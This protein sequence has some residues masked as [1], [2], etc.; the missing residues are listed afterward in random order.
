MNGGLCSTCPNYGFQQH[1]GECWHDSFSML[2]LYSDEL[3]EHIQNIFDK[4]FDK[5]AEY[6]E[7]HSPKYLLPMN[8]EPE[9]YKE[10]IKWCKD[11]FN[12]MYNRYNN[13]KLTI[14]FTKPKKDIRLRS[15]I[16]NGGVD[17]EET[18]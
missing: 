9:N 14:F 13:E 7:I 18:V 1:N 15:P 10:Y 17:L 5:C 8:I 12:N 16:I 3:S 6:A 11:Y 2:M 4:D